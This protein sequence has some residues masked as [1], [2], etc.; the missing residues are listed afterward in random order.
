MPASN[1]DRLI[2][3]SRYPRSGTTKTRMIPV[4]G[5]EGAAELQRRMTEH[6][7]ATASIL[8]REQ[9]VQIEIHFED[10][11]PV[12]MKS[13]LGAVPEY[14]RQSQGDIGERMQHALS[15][16]FSAGADRTVLI[17]TDI[18]DITAEIL[19]KA[20]GVL[21]NSDLVLGPAADGG[22]YLIGARA[23]SYKD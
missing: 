9:P 21:E 5:A 10:S 22:Y 3:F 18:P 6:T 8:A 2:I 16:A 4:M 23:E 15:E 12:Q 13:W 20:Y 17:G 1:R 7:L 11:N 14:R 19:K